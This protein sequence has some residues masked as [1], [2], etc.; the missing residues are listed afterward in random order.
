MQ[1]STVLC[2]NVACSLFRLS[3]QS[4]KRTLRSLCAWS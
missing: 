1:Q 4:N 2:I 3:Y